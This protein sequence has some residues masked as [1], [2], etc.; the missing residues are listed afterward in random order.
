MVK[1][2]EVR[3]GGTNRSQLE[4]ETSQDA[5]LIK[6]KNLITAA[7]AAPDESNIQQNELL[8]Q[9]TPKLNLKPPRISQV[10]N[11]SYSTVDYSNE[12]RN[13]SI[14]IK[15]KDLS[16]QRLDESH[17][18]NYPSQ[19]DQAYRENNDSS[20]L[21]SGVRMGNPRSHQNSLMSRNASM[22]SINSHV[23]EQ[24]YP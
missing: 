10:I 12:P 9:S 17:S 13:T 2:G 20:Q 8:Y 7:A 16:R 21:S 14:E 19:Q 11:Q 6:K 22:P 4:R 3:R 5:I 18:S 23:I 15:D 1:A 24:V